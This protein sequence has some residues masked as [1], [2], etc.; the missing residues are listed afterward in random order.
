[1]DRRNFLKVLWL[2]L[3]KWASISTS[4]PVQK[5]I[6][7]SLC[8]VNRIHDLP[9]IKQVIS[10]EIIG[11]FDISCAWTD[12]QKIYE[13]TSF[14][15]KILRMVDVIDELKW[16]GFSSIDSPEF[17]LSYWKVDDMESYASK[18]N[19]QYE[20]IFPKFQQTLDNIDIWNFDLSAFYSASM[21]WLQDN[22][23]FHRYSWHE[24]ISS[25]YDE[26]RKMI[27][28]Y[29]GCDDDWGIPEWADILYEI[30]LD[31]IVNEK[32]NTRILHKW[33]EVINNIKKVYKI[34]KQIELMKNKLKKIH[35]FESPGYDEYVTVQNV[36]WVYQ[37][38]MVNYYI[39]LC[40]MREEVIDP[41]EFVTLLQEKKEHK[42]D[43]WN[44]SWISIHKKEEEYTVFKW[45]EEIFN[46]PIIS[47]VIFTDEFISLLH[48]NSNI[49]K[50]EW[51]KQEKLKQSA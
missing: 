29:N 33:T 27:I 35:S 37:R 34:L 21:G 19:E 51:E 10:E 5:I 40:F 11:L 26:W 14:F 3:T 41:I 4:L 7:S 24:D 32:L 22:E 39:N 50:Y 1:M 15:Q 46:G 31:E 36:I 23:V 45:E 17:D 12:M 42:E 49:V 43:L 25:D 20:N 13:S 30:P 48:E 16:M 8:N 47:D 44:L 2:G 38:K 9:V 18:L 6:T 28:V